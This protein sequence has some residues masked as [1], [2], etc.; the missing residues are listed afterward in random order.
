MTGSSPAGWP[1]Y[2]NSKLVATWR[3]V[4]SYLRRR[5]KVLSAWSSLVTIVGLPLL[6]LGGLT[7][8]IQ[9][10]DYLVRPDIALVFDTPTH[11]RFW[12][13][14]L[15]PV[16]ADEPEYQFALWNLD[17]RAKGQGKDPGNLRIPVKGLDYV[18]PKSARGPWRISSLS[19]SAE[20]VP[21]GHV[22][23]G[24]AAV[25]CAECQSR[26]DYW[27]FWRKGEKA[28][29]YE[30][31]PGAESVETSRGLARWCRLFKSD[32][33]ACAGREAN[34]NHRA[35]LKSPP[36]DGKPANT[37]KNGARPHPAQF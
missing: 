37:P 33:E 18:R 15:S 24:R 12:V 23:F 28:W 27:L 7:S 25:Q 26:R 34:F 3:C 11:L 2:I 30:I 14:N 35:P 10:R 36:T 22:I 8:Y 29:Y 5:S 21:A 31:P 9:L 6:I 16:L 13:V 4:N 1:K 19:K 20:A 32:L 17:E